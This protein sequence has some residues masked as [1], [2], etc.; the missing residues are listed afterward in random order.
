MTNSKQLEKKGAKPISLYR[1]VVCILV[2]GLVI[3]YTI[4]VVSGKINK[5]RQIDTVHLGLVVLT[6]VFITALLRPELFK[7]LKSLELTGFKLEMLEKVKE[8]QAEQE[9]ILEDISLILPLLLPRTERKHLFNLDQ[10]KTKRYKGN[11][12]LRAE[13]RRLRSIGLLKMRPKHTVSQMKTDTEF[14][15]SEY[16]E[17]TLLGEYWV[18]RISDIEKGDKE[19][20]E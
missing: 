1:I 5:E 16:M 15:L 8:K 14:D 4:G 11:S 10:G 12:T 18:K 3:S 20:E 7:R 6:I 2:G 17:L 19:K 13:L 9:S